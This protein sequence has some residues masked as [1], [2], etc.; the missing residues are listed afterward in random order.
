MILSLCVSASRGCEKLVLSSALIFQ[1]TVR[2]RTVE[3]GTSCQPTSVAPFSVAPFKFS[4]CPGFA[5]ATSSDKRARVQTGRSVQLQDASVGGPRGRMQ[6]S[7]LHS[8]EMQ[9][10]K[11]RWFFNAGERP[12]NTTSPYQDE[13]RETQ[14]WQQETTNS[15][16]LAYLVTSLI[17]FTGISGLPGGHSFSLPMLKSESP[18]AAQNHIETTK[19]YEWIRSYCLGNL[20]TTYQ[21]K[22]LQRCSR[23]YSNVFQLLV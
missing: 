1:F 10:F 14:V 11:G 15:M 12:F 23:T 2:R 7:A 4:Q 5:V 22:T 19:L 16:Q 9:G 20:T 18:L 8:Q 13:R 6:Q 21:Q 3:T 17:S